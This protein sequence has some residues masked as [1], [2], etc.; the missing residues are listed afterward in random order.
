MAKREFVFFYSELF[1]MLLL[2]LLLILLLLV[3]L[4]FSVLLLVVNTDG[5]KL[6]LLTALPLLLA[7]K[8][9]KADG[10]FLP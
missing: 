10:T 5:V 3:L 7:K 2:L 8:L 9:P 6:A 4:L 1:V